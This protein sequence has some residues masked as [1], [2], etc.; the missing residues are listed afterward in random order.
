[1][2]Y[3]SKAIKNA[4]YLTEGRRRKTQSPCLSNVI[5]V[6]QGLLRPRPPQLTPETQG[7]GSRGAGPATATGDGGPRGPLLR[8]V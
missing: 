3:L 7:Y 4:G 5:S 8:K 2:I 1:M 6:S